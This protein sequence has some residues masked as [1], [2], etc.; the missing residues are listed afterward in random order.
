MG[1]L[2]CLFF[3]MLMLL[4]G[5]GHT[6]THTHTQNTH[7]MN[8]TSFFLSSVCFVLITIMML[9]LEG[10]VVVVVVVGGWVV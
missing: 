9:D 4:M 5:W 2:D 6:H 8:V 10:M 3:F 7:Q 1:G